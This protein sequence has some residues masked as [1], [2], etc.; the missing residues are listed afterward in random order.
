MHGEIDGLRLRLGLGLELVGC[1]SVVHALPTQLGQMY[2]PPTRTMTDEL[3]L[4]TGLG[5]AFELVNVANLKP[6]L[7]LF[8]KPFSQDMDHSTT[9]NR[10]NMVEGSRSILP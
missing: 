3:R 1:E 10:F 5:F 6:Y 7:E 9:N 8:Q 2:T 4:G